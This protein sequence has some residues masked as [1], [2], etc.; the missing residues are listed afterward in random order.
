MIIHAPVVL[1]ACSSPWWQTRRSFG[2]RSK[3]AMPPWTEMTS[4]GNSSNHWRCSSCSIR[5]GRVSH[6]RRMYYTHTHP[7]SLLSSLT[8]PRFPT[9][10]VVYYALISTLWYSQI[11]FYHYTAEWINTPAS[12]R[13]GSSP[14]ILP[15]EGSALCTP[16]GGTA[17]RLHLRP[18]QQDL[19]H[20]LNGIT[21][22]SGAPGQ[23]LKSHP[24]ID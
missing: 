2:C 11:H 19:L 4:L 10:K 20:L 21:R 23:S 16:A 3:L 17:P 8:R 13:I 18:P 24:L 1:A 6:D 7:L 9:D 14:P 5:S 12:G 22:T 15:S